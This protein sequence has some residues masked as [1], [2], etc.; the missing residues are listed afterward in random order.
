MVSELEEWLRDEYGETTMNIVSRWRKE[1][2]MD[3]DQ[4][5]RLARIVAEEV[6][7]A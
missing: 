6:G 2:V 4:I 5:R 1:V 3:R 7:E